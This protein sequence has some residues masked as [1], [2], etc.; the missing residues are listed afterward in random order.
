M[1]LKVVFAPAPII[2]SRFDRWR[3]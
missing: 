3:S 2:K 1:L